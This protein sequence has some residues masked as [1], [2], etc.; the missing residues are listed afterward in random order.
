ME[1]MYKGRETIDRERYTPIDKNLENI[2]LLFLAFVF[3]RVWLDWC[4]KYNVWVKNFVVMVKYLLYSERNKFS[5][6]KQFYM[7][8]TST[9]QT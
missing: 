7:K 8:Y 6:Y 4:T 9:Y 5:N 3:H 1:D 2:A